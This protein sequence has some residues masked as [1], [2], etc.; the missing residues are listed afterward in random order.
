MKNKTL[1]ANFAEIRRQA[2]KIAAESSPQRNFE[3]MSPEEIKS[4]LHE[5]EVHQ[6]ELEMQNEELLRAHNE[7]DISRERY[8]NLYNLAPVGYLTLSEKG[9]ILEA[10]LT[11]AILLNLSRSKLIKQLLTHFILK[12]DQ[13]IYY[14]HRKQV[15]D[16][17]IPKTCVVRMLKTDGASFWAQILTSIVKEKGRAT[18]Y[19]VTITDVTE[20]QAY[21][22]KIIEMEAMKVINQAKSDLLA[23][24]SHELRTPLVSI[25]GFIETLIEPD[26]KWSKKQQLD[27]LMSANKEADHLTL[28]IKDLLDMSRIDSS[29]LFLDK[30]PYK[31]TEILDSVSGVLSIIT[32]KHKLDIKTSTRLPAVLADKSR[33]GQVITNLVE[34]ATKFSSAG[35]LIK[36]VVKSVNGNVEFSIEDQGIGMTKNEVNNLFNRFYQAK[37]VVVGK[38]RG[39]GLGLTICKGIIEAHGCKIWVES[40]TGKGSKFIFTL[41]ATV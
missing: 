15:K 10:N 2:E 31:V 21:E 34:N 36:I 37:Q 39:T 6:I 17:D 27:F 19:R 28:L 8:F 9:V 18:T 35:S 22:A 26:V 38:S 25:K 29:K 16:T 40:H 23:N 11:A 5:L 30:R 14:I 4:I 13:D 3:K 24:V 7:L 1:A 32:S 12:E 20:H 33:I 41:P